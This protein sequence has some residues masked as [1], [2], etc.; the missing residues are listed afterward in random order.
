MK[1]TLVVVAISLLTACAAQQTKEQSLVNRAAEAVG[2]P[3]REA[4]RTVNVKGPPHH[5]EPEQSEGP[6]RE[7]GSANEA[8]WQF[9]QGLH[10]QVSR[11][12]WEK[13]FLEGSPRTFK[14]RE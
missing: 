14:S 3:Q 10:Y 11:S 2:G 9:K 6:V 13:E 7:M 4:V 8:N 5:W 1:R 12:G